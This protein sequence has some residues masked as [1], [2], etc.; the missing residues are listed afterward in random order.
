M[1]PDTDLPPRRITEERLERMRLTLPSDCWSRESAYRALGVPEDLVAP[2]AISPHVALFEELTRNGGVSPVFA[3]VV[4]VRMVKELKRAGCATGTLTGEALRRGADRPS[5][6]KAGEG[7]SRP[8][9]ESG[10]RRRP[11][12][13]AIHS[14]TVHGCRSPCRGQDGA[15]EAR[16]RTDPAAG[17]QEGSRDGQGHARTSRESGWC[18]R[19]SVCRGGT[20]IMTGDEFKG[21]RGEALEVLRR[22]EA[23]IWSDVEI[24]TDRGSF[25]G[26][27]L[28]RS[29]TADPHHVVLKLPIGYNIGIAARRIQGITI[30][31]RREAKYKIPEKEFPFDPKKPR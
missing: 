28:P 13:R 4:L 3:S 7:G 2:L 20:W 26:I 21:Y 10:L 31:G 16:G 19:R 24:A 1:Y 29:E 25:A 27:I 9:V 30:R 6:R 17:P 14:S 22:F 8:G 11:V 12:R 23:P 5:I 15:G 18:A